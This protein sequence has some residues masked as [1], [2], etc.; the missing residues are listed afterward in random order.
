MTFPGWTAADF[1]LFAIPDFPG[2]M[3]EIRARL[4][5]KLL[6]L[7]ED[8]T[9]ALTEI[10][11]Q[12]VFPHVAQHMRRRVNPPD[13]TWVAWCRDKKGYKRWTHYRIAVSGAGVRTTVFV[14]DDADDKEAFAAAL[15]SDARKLMR[16]LGKSAPILWYTFGKAPIPQ[17]RATAETLVEGGAALA[18]LKLQKFQ[19]GI[20][21]TREEAL[22]QSPE[23]FE[24]WASGQMAVL[25]P[26]YLLGRRK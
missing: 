2:R 24:E 15:Q 1:D 17:K 11:G 8:L 19:A 20:Q 14:E 4:R 22:G 25:K 26:L 21:I 12:P 13:E 16:A 6:A 5:P 7:A 23:A 10:V 18:R 9:P 3:A